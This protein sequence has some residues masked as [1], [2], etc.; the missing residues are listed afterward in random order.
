M[1]GSLIAH[2][3]V[4]FLVMK[5]GSVVLGYGLPGQTCALALLGFGECVF[6]D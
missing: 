4:Q 2:L 1:L 5:R 3:L 6:L